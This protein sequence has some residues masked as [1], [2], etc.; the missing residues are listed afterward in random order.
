MVVWEVLPVASLKILVCFAS[1]ARRRR[2]EEDEG[3]LWSPPGMV[4]VDEVTVANE[5][6]EVFDVNPQAGASDMQSFD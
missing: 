3:E 6:R 1:A 5:A 4:E 2:W